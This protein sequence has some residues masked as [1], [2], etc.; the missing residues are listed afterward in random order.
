[1]FS[2]TIAHATTYEYDNLNRLTRVDFENGNSIDYT[3]DQAGNRLTETVTGTGGEAPPVAQFSATPTSGQAP[4]AVQFSDESSGSPTSWMW[5]F[6]DGGTSSE[7]SPL[8]TYMAAG[9]YTVSLTVTNAVEGDTETKQNLISVTTP[10]DTSD[11]IALYLDVGAGAVRHAQVALGATFDL[12]VMTDTVEGSTAGEFVLTDVAN[13]V[14]GVLRTSITK[15]NDTTFDL[16]DDEL[17]EYYMV[18]FGCVPPGPAEIVRIEYANMAG[19][20]PTDPG[21]QRSRIPAR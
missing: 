20:L 3:Y 11:T 17:G 16:G 18:Y 15:I 13:L 12:I 5:E 9:S 4:L 14:P 21:A 19:A 2:G 6:G 1:M 7:S 10:V 8:H